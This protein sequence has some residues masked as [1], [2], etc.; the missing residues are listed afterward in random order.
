MI[1]RKQSVRFD[2]NRVPI[3]RSMRVGYEGDHLVER[4]IFEV[5]EI[6]SEQ[7][8]FLMLDGKY[9]DVAML[10]KD[11][12]GRY[13]VDLTADM[14]G[15]GGITDGRIQIRGAN[16]SVWNSGVLR[17]NIGELPGMDQDIET[18]YPTAIEQM[19][20]LMAE[21]SPLRAEIG[22][23]YAGMLLYVDAD[24]RIA[25]LKIGGGLAIRDGALVLTG[26]APESEMVGFAVDDDGNTYLKGVEFVLQADESILLDGAA[27]E[28]Q[29]DGSVLLN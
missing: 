7:T 8:V 3:P 25:P 21:W 24:G 9:A 29:K 1:I 26:S 11:A 23:Q 6:D 15:D 2:A 5:P 18:R 22:A 14:L 12:D 16:G 13:F 17:M 4:L 27:F 10:E 19:M 20:Q 28:S